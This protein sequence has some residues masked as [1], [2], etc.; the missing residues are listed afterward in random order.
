MMVHDR[1]CAVWPKFANWRGP[2]MSLAAVC[3]ALRRHGLNI[4]LA[5]AFICSLTAACHADAV[6][7]PRAR[8][9][10]AASA[11][12]VVFPLKV[13]A[14][15][16][17]LVDQNNVPFLMIGDSPQDLIG[18]LSPAQ[19]EYFMANRQGYGVN[20]LWVNLL[21]NWGTFC[22]VDG[23][24]YD[25]I[26]PFTEPGDLATPNPVYFQ[27]AADMINLAASHGMLVVLDP[28]ETIGW[29]G[30][31]RANGTAKAYAYGQYLGS[32]F[33]G[34]PNI[35]WMHGNDFQS[36]TI[37]ELDALVRAVADGI[38]SIERRHIQTVILN[39]VVSASLDDQSWRSLIGV[40]AV[41]TYRPTYAKLLKEYRR[42][43]FKP[44]FMAEA[45]YEF[46]RNP[47]TD[48]GTTQNLRKQ[49]YWTA[50][51][52][53]AG[54]L[55]GSYYTW[56]FPAYWELNLDTPGVK[57]LAI[58]AQLFGGLRWYDLIPDVPARVFINGRGVYNPDGS[59]TTNNFAAAASTPDGALAV[60]YLPT[61]RKL[62]ADLAKLA[63]PVTARWFD[64]VNGAATAVAG[65]PFPNTGVQEFTPPG[66]NS[67]GDGD[68]VLI[69]EAN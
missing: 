63:G 68:W 31:L 18:K 55:Y 54:Q 40:D 24:T 12:T 37:P 59:I 53:A 2:G 39:Y 13:S 65:S 15:R 60:A 41:Y 7:P 47:S 38:R 23:T 61:V 57:Q 52:G 16:R 43:W 5:F 34:L 32:R 64:P 36:W 51:S 48:G 22:N 3:G 33:R 50:L 6:V 35:L 69:L 44:T 66:P 46:E 56:H 49:E 14:N 45:N 1:V 26:A 67:A 29:L 21:C 42:T 27:R 58:M 9:T 4:I 19:A 10:K 62:T 8:L 20:A 25:G 30:V 28:I 11:P 17:T